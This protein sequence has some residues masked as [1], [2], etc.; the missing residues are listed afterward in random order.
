MGQDLA[1][2]GVEYFVVVAHSPG[3]EDQWFGQVTHVEPV[4]RAAYALPPEAKQ[5]VVENE[6][7]ETRW[8][9]AALYISNQNRGE[10][11]AK[12]LLQA[13]FDFATELDDSKGSLLRILIHP[14]NL[15]ARKSHSSMGFFDAGSVTLAEAYI[16]NGDAFLVPK[17]G[18]GEH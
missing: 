10:S 17:D 14:D 9:I 3:E 4:S 13:N 12:L 2:P 11:L 1:R 5:P 16:S 7:E 15:V 18:G 6:D 8:Q